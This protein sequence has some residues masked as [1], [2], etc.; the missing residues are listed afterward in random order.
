M[1]SDTPSQGSTPKNAAIV[2]SIIAAIALV[3]FGAWSLQDSKENDSGQ[4]E[5]ITIGLPP[6]EPSALVYIAEN[7]FSL[8]LDQSLILTMEDEARWMIKNN[9]TAEREIPDFRDY[10]YT[11]GLDDVKPGSVS[12]IN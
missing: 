4:I 2:I 11:R 5:S 8:S 1:S 10:I 3:R 12:V 7:H 6:L 9:L